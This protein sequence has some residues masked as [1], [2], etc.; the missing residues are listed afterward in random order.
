MKR[1]GYD[2]DTQCYYFKDKDGS[3]WRGVP[4]A[5]YSEMTRG[6]FLFPPR[7]ARGLTCVQYQVPA[8][9]TTT[10]GPRSG[11]LKKPGCAQPLLG[12]MDINCFRPTGYVDILTLACCPLTCLPARNGSKIRHQC[13]CLP[14]PIPVL[15]PNL[16]RTITCL[17]AC[18]FAYFNHS[19]GQVVPQTTN[20]AAPRPTRRY[21]LGDSKSS[22]MLL[23]RTKRIERQS[24]LRQVNAWGSG[25]CSR[26]E[27]QGKACQGQEVIQELTA[28]RLGYHL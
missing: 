9:V 8:Q 17:A 18:S 1:I 10:Q 11:T 24:T 14:H 19:T 25:L 4:G 23:G 27:D 7:C 28:E 20:N 5:R 2:D 12:E 6:S 26:G 3:I 13:W 22:G 21:L 15:P 16:R